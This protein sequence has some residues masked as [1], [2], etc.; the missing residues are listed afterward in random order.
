ML[1]QTQLGRAGPAAAPAAHVVVPEERGKIGPALDRLTGV[2]SRLE[3][4]EPRRNLYEE[5]SRKIAVA[6]SRLEG[7]RAALEKDEKRL[8]QLEGDRA[9]LDELLPQEEDYKEVQVL[10]ARLEE[11]RERYAKISLS[12]N[13]QTT[14][15]TKYHGCKKEY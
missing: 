6:K 13:R 14:K 15:I 5:I 12:Q 7:D 9:R 10:L 11:L 8:V 3:L 2:L 4:L 1:R